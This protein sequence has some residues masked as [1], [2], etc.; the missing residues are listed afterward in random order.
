MR[1]RHRTTRT[2]AAAATA[3]VATAGLL[4]ATTAPTSA[5]A[6]PDTSRATSARLPSGAESRAGGFALPAG[7]LRSAVSPAAASRTTG[8]GG[9]GSQGGCSYYANNAGMG[10]YC[11][12]AGGGADIPTLAEQFGSLGRPVAVCKYFRVPEGM[13]RPER[14]LDDGM[15]WVLKGCL[16][17]IDWDTI[18]GG[19]D[20]RIVMDWEQARVGEGLPDPGN[21]VLIDLL[22]EE[23]QDSYPMP[24]PEVSPSELPR[25]NTDV[26]FHFRWV[27]GTDADFP[28][29]SEGPNAG[30]PD[31]APYTELTAGGGTMRAEAV[32]LRI[33]PMVKGMEPVTC[34]NVD[35][36]PFDESAGDTAEDQDT[37]CFLKFE[38]S[39][40]AAEELSTSDLPD[41]GEYA[42][43]IRFEVTY[44]VTVEFAQPGLAD[45]NLGTYQMDTYQQLPVSQAPGIIYGG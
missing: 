22:W 20:M 31:G 38:S 29:V 12:G 15:Y 39:S 10:M 32:G 45:D 44:E 43:L 13:E 14:D 2:L 4:G 33:V 30:D 37:S 1:V 19:P 11:V 40:A 42:F 5:T 36:P 41:G 8:D 25:V 6:T 27:D 26:M 34:R 35:P 17:D 7:S 24:L 3:L 16:V 9:F 23:A 21:Q 28:P 18:D